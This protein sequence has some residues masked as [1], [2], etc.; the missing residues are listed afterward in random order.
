MHLD[1]RTNKLY[2]ADSAA[3]AIQVIDSGWLGRDA[4]ANDDVTDK[5][6]RRA[7][8]ALRGARARQRDHRLQHG[9]A[10]PR[11]QK[12]Q[13]QLPATLSVIKLR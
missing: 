7:R 3:N 4:R 10:V 2:M 9:L 1:P 6:H 12:H 5:K 13:I 8:P 11:L